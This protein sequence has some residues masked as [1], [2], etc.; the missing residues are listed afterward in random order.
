VIESMREI[1]KRNKPTFLRTSS[2]HFRRLTPQ[3]DPNSSVDNDLS[4]SP[5]C[6]RFIQLNRLAM[7][8]CTRGYV[9]SKMKLPSRV[10]SS[11][12]LSSDAPRLRQTSTFPVLSLTSTAQSRTQQVRTTTLYQRPSKCPM[13][14]RMP[15]TIDSGCG[16]QPAT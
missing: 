3:H 5:S 8:N 6:R 2:T 1:R 16:G 14:S 15:L 13:R 10:I 7:E 4:G 12:G 9:E 11:N